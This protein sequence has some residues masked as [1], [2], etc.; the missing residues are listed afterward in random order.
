MTKADASQN[1][2]AMCHARILHAE[3]DHVV[4]RCVAVCL[5]AKEHQIES[6]IHGKEALASIIGPGHYEV[7]IFDHSMLELDGVECARV[8]R[9]MGYSGKILVFASPLP[10]EKE[11]QW[12]GFSAKTPDKLSLCRSHPGTLERVHQRQ[13]NTIRNPSLLWRVPRAFPS[14]SLPRSPLAQLV[15]APLHLKRFLRFHNQDAPGQ[16]AEVGVATGVEEQQQ[17][18]T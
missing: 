15:G 10:L 3:D 7:L 13:M 8:L 5:G 1:S 18:Q 12:I 9:K 14:G 2:S 6:V 11:Q 4:A 16:T 17:R